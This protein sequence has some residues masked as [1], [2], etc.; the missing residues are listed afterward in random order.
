MGMKSNK[1]KESNI[2]SGKKPTNLGKELVKRTQD[3]NR[4]IES[5]MGKSAKTESLPFADGLVM[6][7]YPAGDSSNNYVRVDFNDYSTYKD[8]CMI[9]DKS[10]LREVADFINKYLENN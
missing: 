3:L 6:Y 8:Y 1:N 5:I 4:N 7:L 9:M 2:K 10:K